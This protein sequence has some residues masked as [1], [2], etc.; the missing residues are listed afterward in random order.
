MRNPRD[1]FYDSIIGRPAGYNEYVIYN[2][3]QCCPLYEISYD[4]QVVGKHILNHFNNATDEL[5]PFIWLPDN[6]NCAIRMKNVCEKWPFYAKDLF[7]TMATSPPSSIECIDNL[8]QSVEANTEE[9]SL[10]LG[11]LPTFKFVDL[12]RSNDML[13]L[14]SI[15]GVAL[16]R[17]DETK[18]ETN[19]EKDV[20]LICCTE[21]TTIMITPGLWKELKCGHK[22]CLACYHNLLTTRITMSR[23]KH[24]FIRCPFCSDVTGT[25][26]AVGTCPDIRMIIRMIPNSCEGYEST[27]TISIQYFAD[28][29]YKLNRTAYLPN[30]QE[31]REVLM[32]LEKACDRRFCFKVGDS[33][34]TGRKNVLVWAIHHKTS[35]RGGVT[36]YGYPDPGYFDR[37]KSELK[38]YGIQ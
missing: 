32:L 22:L 31:G 11:T 34:T 26:G 8:P 35:M 13:E 25:N 1:I 23:V 33:L 18:N 38:S 15:P 4:S 17:E 12:E 9:I 14:D 29:E 24:T 36:S 2:R 3:Y 7:R 20:C 27:N 5:P 10:M 19:P 37:V 16:G 21:Y 28:S 30:T 6:S